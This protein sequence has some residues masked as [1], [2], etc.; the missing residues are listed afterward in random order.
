MK[1]RARGGGDSRPLIVHVVHRL[2]TGGLENGVVNLV[3]GLPV[4]AYRHAIVALDDV[5]DF[6]RRVNRDDVSYFALHKKPGQGFWLFP[7]LFGLFRKLAPA[8]VHTRNLAALEAAAPAW[9]AGVRVRIHG[10][11]GRD[12]QDLDGSNRTYRRV[13]RFY[14]PFVSRYV[15]LSKDLETYL[16]DAI[17]VDPDV[18]SQI[19]NGVDTAR[20][21]PAA[22]ARPVI[23]GCPFQSENLW[24]VGTVGRMQAV[25]DQLTLA[26][27]FIEAVRQDPA[28]GRRLRLV[29][30]GD[31]PLRGEVQAMLECAHMAHLAWLPGERDDIPAVLRGLN[32]FVLPSLAEGVSN[33]ILEAMACGVPVV[34][35]RVGGNAELVSDGTTGRLVPAA[36]PDAMA[37]PLLAYCRAP[38][39]AARHGIAGREAILQRFSLDR[40][41][42]QYAA[43]YDRALGG[44]TMLP[45]GLGR[46]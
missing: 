5:T 4:N 23:A 44:V 19:Y 26:R 7:R 37:E 11:H 46:A 43:L 36:D 24:L 3:N 29:I 42:G 18:I 21:A 38:D 40:M 25:K 33:T 6:R 34:A 1:T 22:G 45:I 28:A 20:F 15:A 27:S 32:C 13:R 31:G 39:M 12:M 10:E 16:H 17:G 8:I 14:R 9:A 2:D 30:V 41:V 35:T